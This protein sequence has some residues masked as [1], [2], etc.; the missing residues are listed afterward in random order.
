MS[1]WQEKLPKSDT[2]LVGVSGRLDQSLN[3]K[4][5][6]TLNELLEDGQFHLVVDLIPADVESRL[7]V[8]AAAIPGEVIDDLIGVLRLKV[9]VG[10]GV[11]SGKVDGASERKAGHAADGGII[12]WVADS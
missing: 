7:D 4:L 9:P 2:W 3:P 10:P 5:E 11:G 6:E 8:V 12:A 1:V